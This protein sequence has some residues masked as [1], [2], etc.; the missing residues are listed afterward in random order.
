MPIGSLARSS[1]RWAGFRME[2]A[3]IP[4]ELS[5][6]VGAPFVAWSCRD[7]GQVRGIDGYEIEREIA[8]EIKR[9]YPSMAVLSDDRRQ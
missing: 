5:E 2:S 7:E 3:P 1:E 6:A 9:D 4:H 8:D